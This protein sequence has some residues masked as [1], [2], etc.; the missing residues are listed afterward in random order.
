MDISLK[1]IMLLAF[2][3]CLAGMC[4]LL[5][6]LIER[7][8]DISSQIRANAQHIEESAKPESGSALEKKAA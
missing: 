2:Y 3:W 1:L 4:R 6:N 8:I 7:F 5:L